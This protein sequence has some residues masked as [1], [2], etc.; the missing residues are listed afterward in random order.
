M[1]KRIYRKSSGVVD[2]D[3]AGEFILVPL[4]ATPGDS[5]SIYNLNVLGSRIW[6]LINGKRS[7]SDIAQIIA[8]E[9]DGDPNT[10]QNDTADFLAELARLN[11]IRFE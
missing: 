1:N 7:V 9:F 3:I 11:F 5:D 10:I 6:G 4:H 8:D 2:R